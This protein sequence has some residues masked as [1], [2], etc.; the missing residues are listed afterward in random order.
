[1]FKPFKVLFFSL[2]VTE[3]KC[4]M[5]SGFCCCLVGAVVG[6]GPPIAVFECDEC[7]CHTFVIGNQN[8]NL[9]MATI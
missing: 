6:A 2:G 3:T 8:I 1:M 9:M 4:L 5:K 7:A